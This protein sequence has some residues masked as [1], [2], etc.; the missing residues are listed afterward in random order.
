MNARAKLR[1]SLTLPHVPQDRPERFYRFSP[2]VSFDG[3][4]DGRAWNTRWLSECRTE[5]RRTGKVSGKGATTAIAGTQ[6]RPVEDLT[7]G[8][9]RDVAR[10]VWCTGSLE[11]DGRIPFPRSNSS[12][13]THVLG[14]QLK[15]FD[16]ASGGFADVFQLSSLSK[17][18]PARARSHACRRTHCQRRLERGH[19]LEDRSARRDR[20]HGSAVVIRESLPT[21]AE[22]RRAIKA[23]DAA[24]KA[25][26]ALAAHSLGD[27]DDTRVKLRSDINE[28]LTY[29]ENA[30]WWRKKSS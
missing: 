4:T 7:R 25:V 18:A 20:T 23:L 30:T 16:R 27:A 10:D 28:Y 11:K 17:N 3:S 5:L 12:S 22:V 8:A 15:L 13:F 26:G 24:Y 29:L 9:C 6:A 14:E 21:E 1:L 2:G 19:D